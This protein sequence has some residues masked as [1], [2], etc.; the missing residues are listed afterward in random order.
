MYAIRNTHYIP[1]IITLLLSLYALPLI[2][3]SY[4]PPIPLRTT[5]DAAALVSQRVAFHGKGPFCKASEEKP[6]GKT[7]LAEFAD[8]AE[9]KIKVSK[10]NPALAHGGKVHAVSV[11]L[12]QTRK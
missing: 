12:E 8:V 6:R 7:K 9:V 10:L 3:A 2:A 11:T 4:P 1:A 5:P